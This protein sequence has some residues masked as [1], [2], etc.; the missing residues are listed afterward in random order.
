VDLKRYEAEIGE[1]DTVKQTL[2]NTEQELSNLRVKLAMSLSDNVTEQKALA[3]SDYTQMMNENTSLKN[4]LEALQLKMSKLK[5]LKRQ[6]D[7][8]QAQAAQ[9]KT[10]IAR[11]QIEDEQAKRRISQL[12]EYKAKLNELRAQLADKSPHEEST[13]RQEMRRVVDENKLLQA[14]AS[15]NE[16]MVIAV[17]Q[18]KALAESTILELN[19]LKNELKKMELERDALNARAQKATAYMM[20]RN[21]LR[22]QLAHVS[23]GDAPVAAGGGESE[24]M[25]TEM[26]RL[27]AENE[28][29][30]K[31]VEATERAKKENTVLTERIKDLEGK[32]KAARDRIKELEQQSNKATESKTKESVDKVKAENRDLE[33]ALEKERAMVKTLKA[34]VEKVTKKYDQLREKD[35]KELEDKL[36]RMEIQHKQELVVLDKASKEDN[37]KKNR[38]NE[39][40]K[41]EIQ[42]LTQER[43]VLQKERAELESKVKI[44]SQN[45]Q[46][47]EVELAKLKAAEAQA[48]D[49]ASKVEQLSAQI[50]KQKTDYVVMEKKYKDEMIQRKRLHNIIEDMKGKIRVYCRARPISQKETDMGS[51]SIVTIVD[52]FTIKV[53]TKY[54]PKSFSFDAAFGPDSSQEKVFEDTKRLV[55]SAVDGYNVCIFAYGQTGAGKS[56]TIQGSD[57]N[58][59]IAPRSFTEMHM[60]L[61]NMNNYNYTMECYMV[62]LYLD[63]LNDLLLP[64]DMRKNPPHLDI[65]EDIKGLMY[66]PA[67]TKIP[68]RNAAEAKRIFDLGLNNRKTFATDMNDNSSRS[69][70]VFSI[71]VESVNRQTNQKAV[72]KIS[73]VDLAGSERA[74]KAGTSADRLK[75]GRAINKSLS[76]LGDVIS[77]L[78]SGCM[79]PT[80]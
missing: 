68:I 10:F 12:E 77:T 62:E 72:G 44:L 7:D 17:A 70:L 29:L 52:E 74:S 78:S 4:K 16:S 21:A 32:L 13:M 69:H 60:I 15:G 30:L 55:Q 40:A 36:K 5:D 11:M 19:K 47:L 53:E 35:F 63:T 8:L 49:L 46:R 22:V 28:K 37:T 54:G 76:A 79:L 75:E 73:F 71:I 43:D 80:F 45:V 51:Q 27:L 61:E 66:I 9:Q 6:Y 33:K 18:N 2:V 38:E 59:G 24:A 50:E 67:A 25:K 1:L 14:A 58:P 31:N 56:Y 39:L 41:A 23:Q 3:R 65:K 64:K 34:E 20:E 57:D 26:T 42:R 48:V